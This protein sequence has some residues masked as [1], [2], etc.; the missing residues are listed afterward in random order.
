MAAAGGRWPGRLHCANIIDVV[1]VVDGDGD[2]DG[3][4]GD[5]GD[6]DAWLIGCGGRRRRRRRRRKRNF[7]I[8]YI[9]TPDRPPLRLLLVLR[10]LI[11][12]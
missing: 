12:P 8:L 5:D 10:I 6:D 11:A 7:Q 1:V 2:D 3:A 4:D 9:T